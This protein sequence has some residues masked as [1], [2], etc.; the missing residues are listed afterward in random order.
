LPSWTGWRPIPIRSMPRPA[1]AERF[2]SQAR[3]QIR[4]RLLLFILMSAAAFAG[5]PGQDGRR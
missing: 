5:L 4:S 2:R 3:L 1:R